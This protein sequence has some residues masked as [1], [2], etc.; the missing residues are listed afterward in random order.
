MGEKIGTK[1]IIGEVEFE[2]LDYQILDLLNS[3]PVAYFIIPGTLTG[4]QPG[5]VK[6][7]L[8]ID[9]TFQQEFVGFI[10]ATPKAKAG[11]IQIETLGI[12]DTLV[13]FDTRLSIKNPTLSMVLKEVEKIKKINFIKP[14]TD[15]F[16]HP[17]PQFSGSVAAA[18][19]ATGKLYGIQ[20]PVWY[21]M[22]NGSVFF[23]S[24]FDGPW[25][26]KN[27]WVIDKIH[28]GRQ[29]DR[30][31]YK[32]P[33]SYSWVRAGFPISVEKTRHMIAAVMKR[34]ESLYLKLKAI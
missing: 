16:D 11:N 2:V 10:R 31:E 25:T 1:L 32:I 14:D 12:S 9:G 26:D 22:P 27:P 3:P 29:T 33:V 24:W 5:V 23:G 18:I 13:D 28:D 6:F 21:Q 15:Y 19:G 17:V 30:V 8:L 20:A 34:P 4:I 7:Y